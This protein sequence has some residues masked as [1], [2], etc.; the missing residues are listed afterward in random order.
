LLVPDV[1]VLLVEAVELLLEVLPAAEVSPLV[2]PLAEPLGEAD[3]PE[4]SPLVLVLPLGALMLP[5]ALPVEE[6]LG[7]WLVEP[8]APPVVE[9]DP[10]L[11]VLGV[12]AGFEVSVLEGDCVLE[13]VCVVELELDG[14]CIVSVLLGEVVD[15]LLVL[16]EVDGCVV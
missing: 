11:E 8:V 1:L 2:E 13:G 10:E 3:E 14:D 6:P 9:L 15:G 12:C 16:G 5:L 7:V 4:V